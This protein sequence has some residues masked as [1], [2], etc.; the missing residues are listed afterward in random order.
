MSAKSYTVKGLKKGTY[1]KYVVVAYKMTSAG[2][3]VVTTSKSV[4]VATDGG[5]K[6][7]P[8]SLKVKKSKLTVKKGKTVKI[9]ASFKKKKKVAT[10][11]A[12]FRYESTDETIATVDKNGKVKGIGK[13]KCKIYVYTQNGIS[14][15]VTITVK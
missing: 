12:K 10:H 11:I 1:Y 14:K 5:K 3:R 4:H 9:K 2:D 8:T 15:T 13:G 6:G 7:N